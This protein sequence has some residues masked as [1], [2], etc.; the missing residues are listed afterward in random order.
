LKSFG[1]EG[2]VGFGLPG[3]VVKVIY[4]SYEFSLIYCKI[5][6]IGSDV[7]ADLNK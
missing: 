7:M 3:A 1:E 2:I 6:P 5:L 4:E